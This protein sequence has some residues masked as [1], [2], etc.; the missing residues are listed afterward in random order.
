MDSLQ[1]QNHITKEQ[2]DLDMDMNLDD[3]DT[4]PL[5]RYSLPDQDGTLAVTPKVSSEVSSELIHA[6]K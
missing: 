3:F 6:Y 4:L 5:D 1:Y 2:F